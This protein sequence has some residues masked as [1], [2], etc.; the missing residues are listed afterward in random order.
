MR[1][2]ALDMLGPLGHT[3]AKPHMVECALLVTVGWKRRYMDIVDMATQSR[4]THF[5][6]SSG[7]GF[8]D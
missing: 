8:L 2:R 1:S 7:C 5:I 6:A 3:D 4:I